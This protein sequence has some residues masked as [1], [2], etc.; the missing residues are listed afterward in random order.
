MPA[1]TV[2][3]TLVLPRIPRPDPT[4][5]PRPVAKVVTSRR[6]PRAPASSSPDPSP[7]SSRSPRPIRSCCSITSGRSSTRPARRRARR[8]IPTAASRPS[9]TSSTVRSPITT[10]TA[11]A[12]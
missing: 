1:I 8:G 5:R 2:D 7:A 12:A 11:A 9:A 3:D 10:P 6:E 4:D